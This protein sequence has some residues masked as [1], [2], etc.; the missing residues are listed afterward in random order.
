MWSMDLVTIRYQLL[1]TTFNYFTSISKI[2]THDVSFTGDIYITNLP[3]VN[4]S[5]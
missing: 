1:T 4:E 3:L 5:I 2:L